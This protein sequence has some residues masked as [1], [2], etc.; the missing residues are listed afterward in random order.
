MALKAGYGQIA[1]VKNAA[2][3]VLQCIDKR[4]DLVFLNGLFGYNDAR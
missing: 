3:L 4:D 1:I 2:F